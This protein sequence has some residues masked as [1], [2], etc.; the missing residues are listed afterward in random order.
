MPNLFMQLQIMKK[1]GKNVILVLSKFIL[2]KLV[3]FK[4][5]F[6]KLCFD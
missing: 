1:Y 4:F 3:S 2:K 6:N 5:Y